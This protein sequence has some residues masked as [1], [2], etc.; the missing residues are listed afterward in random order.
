MSVITNISYDHKEFLGNTIREIAYEKAGIIKSGIPVV[1]AQQEPEVREVIEKKAGEQQ[2]ELYIYGK[3]FSS[4][5]KKE[6]MPGI[7]FDYRNDSLVLHDLFL[8]LSGE[9]QMQNASV[10]MKAIELLA[11]KS[12]C[13]FSP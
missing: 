9:H 1:T 5:L 2:A 8:P 3:D 7:C 12:R 10:A 11:K 13:R 6:D 4:T